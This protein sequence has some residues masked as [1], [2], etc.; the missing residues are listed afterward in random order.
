MLKKWLKRI[1][2][3]ILIL[4]VLLSVLPYI[5]PT[6]D[7]P[8]FL[9][10]KNYF[11]ESKFIEI[12]RIWLHYRV[13][14]PNQKPVGSVLLIHGFSGSTFS[15]RKNAK[16]LQEKGFQV[17]C[18][19]LPAFG[20]SDRQIE[21]WNLSNEKRIQ[22]LWQ[23]ANIVNPH[24]KWYLVGHSMGASYVW[25]IAIYKPE[26]VA[27]VL[28]VA[29]LPSKFRPYR[30]AGATWLLKYPPVKRWIKVIAENF[31]YK[32]DKFKELLSS[33]YS[34]TPESQDVEGYLAP[35]QVRNTTEAILSTFENTPTDTL[36]V[37]TTYKDFEGKLQL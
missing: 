31:Y 35:F 6:Q 3:A 24:A 29:G 7:F 13:F 8:G 16:F 25:N 32:P 18:V 27:K 9:E 19:D 11:P 4:F 21:H 12:E 5:F 30:S 2:I 23:L 28:C 22:I 14:E 1:G 37:S 36:Q 15:W 26:K 20:F 33:A 10:Q 34:Q 17:L